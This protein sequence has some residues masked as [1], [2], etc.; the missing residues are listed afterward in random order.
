[1]S[2]CYKMITA[3][4]RAHISWIKTKLISYR[5]MQN[6]DKEKFL[7]DLSKF[8]NNFTFLINI[9]SAYERFIGHITKLLD[10][11]DPLKNKKLEGTKVGL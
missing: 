9:N 3:S 10:T 1:M 4:L 5:S 6:F 11:Y 8:T 2:D 7:K